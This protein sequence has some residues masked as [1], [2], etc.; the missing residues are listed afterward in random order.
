MRGHII[1]VLAI[2]LILASS[3]GQ[4]GIVAFGGQYQD[5]YRINL[6]E[7][8]HIKLIFSTMIYRD[9]STLQF[10]IMA[11]PGNA[12]YIDAEGKQNDSWGV[13]LTIKEGDKVRVSQ[14]LTNVFSLA[15][16]TE[17]EMK[18]RI[19][20]DITIPQDIRF[21]NYTLIFMAL[22]N[23]YSTE[24]KADDATK[25]IFAGAEITESLSIKQYLE[26]GRWP[27]ETEKE[28]RNPII[29]VTIAI[30]GFIALIFITRLSIK[31]MK[32]GF[33]DES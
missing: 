8:N 17:N 33:K 10:K 16:R 27:I 1:I 29:Q 30:V 11:T 13:Y 21:G 6:N 15:I 2:S 14:A 19:E 28:T 18:Y 20:I 23:E 25:G 5:Q 32:K 4:A 3:Q 22:S 7:T 12:L 24:T 31:V 26:V 9:N